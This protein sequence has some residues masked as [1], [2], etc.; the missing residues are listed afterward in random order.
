MSLA[1][2][3]PEKIVFQRGQPVTYFTG[4][5]CKFVRTSGRGMCI[6]LTSENLLRRTPLGNIEAIR[7]T[8][9]A[10]TPPTN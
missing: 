10:N 8:P 2:T 3:K 5:K 4:E 9:G 1:K 7:E 6:I